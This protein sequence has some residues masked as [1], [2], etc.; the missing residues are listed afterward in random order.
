[1]MKFLSRPA[2][3]LL[4]PPRIEEEKSPEISLFRFCP[5]TEDEEPWD[6]GQMH[7]DEKVSGEEACSTE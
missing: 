7:F 6:S 2:E 4:P 3:K 1:M 5:L